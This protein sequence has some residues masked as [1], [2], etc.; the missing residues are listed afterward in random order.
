M[1]SE[2]TFQHFRVHTRALRNS[3]WQFQNHIFCKMTFFDRLCGLLWRRPAPCCNKN[4][5]NP[6]TINFSE[7][8]TALNDSPQMLKLT[9]IQIF[10]PFSE[11]FDRKNKIFLFKRCLFNS[12][13]FC[14]QARWQVAKLRRLGNTWTLRLKMF[15]QKWVLIL[16]S[17]FYIIVF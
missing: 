4:H 11:N 7:N 14:Y 1:F 5:I 9:F 10:D 17:H 15:H 8:V 16:T 6:K 2:K 13:Q 3:I 12:V